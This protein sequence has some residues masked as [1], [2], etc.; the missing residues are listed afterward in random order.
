MAA[1]AD[2]A[3]MPDP[4]F[5]IILSVG[6][7][8]RIIIS[9]LEFAHQF[10]EAWQMERAETM[11]GVTIP[12]PP[13]RQRAEGGWRGGGSTALQRRINSGPQ[14]V[15]RD[16]YPVARRMC[17]ARVG[18]CFCSSLSLSSPLAEAGAGSRSAIARR[19][20]SDSDDSV[21]DRKRPEGA[22]F[23]SLAKRTAAQCEQARNNRNRRGK[24][25]HGKSLEEGKHCWKGNKTEQQ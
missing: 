3:T 17:K 18:V 21:S 12:T 2:A 9:R 6:Q 25:R 13:D 16:R 8:R 14:A 15:A 4:S 24:E 20:I 11:H 5:L 22:R 7:R 19:G 1:D 23:R 10:D